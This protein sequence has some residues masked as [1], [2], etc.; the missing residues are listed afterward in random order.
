MN[1][2]QKEEKKEKLTLRNFSFFLA[3]VNVFI[4]STAVCLVIMKNRNE[5]VIQENEKFREEILELVIEKAAVLEFFLTNDFNNLNI[6]VGTNIEALKS[7]EK[8]FT[9]VGESSVKKTV[10]EVKKERF[11]KKKEE[12]EKKKEE[13]SAEEAEVD[14]GLITKIDGIVV[15]KHLPVG[16]QLEELKKLF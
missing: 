15:E 6:N 9:G 16:D 14:S 8:G 2:L 11:E 12:L 1:N 5:K 7:V 13:L 4:V 3:M 10:F